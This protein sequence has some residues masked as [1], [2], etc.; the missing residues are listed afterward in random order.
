MKQ[1]KKN[2]ILSFLI[3]ATIVA[4]CSEQIYE[5]SGTYKPSLESLTL[6]I[7]NRDFNFSSGGGQ[8]TAYVTCDKAWSFHDVPAWLTVSPESGDSDT[9]I[10]VTAQENNT[11]SSRTAVFSVSTNIAGI[12]IKKTISAS[13]AVAEPHFSFANLSSN[14]V[15]L[16]GVAQTMSINVSTNLEDLDLTITG[17]NTSWVQANYLH[18][19]LE[20]SV[21]DNYE[22][23]TRTATIQLWSAKYSKGGIIYL[24]Q[25]RPQISINEIGLLNFD[26]IGG[27]QIV[28]INSELSWF[29]TVDAPWLSV[30][31]TTGAAGVTDIKVTALESGQNSDRTARILFSY[32]ENSTTDNYLNI[33]QK[34]RFVE[35]T[36]N[37][38]NLTADG[39]SSDKV[40]IK[41]NVGWIVTAQPEWVTLSLTQGG[42]GTH[43]VTISATKNNSLN[44]REGQIIIKDSMTGGSEQIIEVQQSGLEYEDP[45]TLELSWHATTLPLSINVP[46]Q[47]EANVSSGWISLSQYSGVG[48]TTIDISVTR[49]DSEELREG[50]VNIISEEK[51]IKIP[52]IQ[53]GQY[54]RIN[55]YTGQFNALGGSTN[56]TLSTTISTEWSIDYTFSSDEW[57][58]VDDSNENIFTLSVDYNPST[59]G[60][61][62]TFII[63]PTDDDV[64]E[65]NTEGVKFEINQLGRRLSCDVGIISM[66]PEGGTSQIYNFTCDGTFEIKK[67]TDE[68]WYTLVADKERKTFYVVLT[69]NTTH[70]LR[71]GKIII[72]LSDLP[73]GETLSHEVTINQA[74]DGIHISFGEF[75]EDE[76][77]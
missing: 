4:S 63:Y 1:Y 57:V 65:S 11:L 54:I 61:N 28:S 77:L 64:A 34:G 15:Y 53:S 71:T 67:E 51:T 50:T 24:T 44:I 20:I 59:K 58:N 30:T 66:F 18:N 62:A 48:E 22:D 27:Q 8:Q 46:Q 38:I 40:E 41:T 52:V 19:V 69:E 55:N 45:S 73:N 13:Q 21:E 49:N 10:T 68:P 60:R 9:Y 29:A 70:N 31:P 32:K 33:N 42:A 6:R 36:P 12:Q 26:A 7:S 17:D 3:C 47:W 72:S 14:T 74:A 25:N 43:S 5:E 23:I 39:A 56:L 75:G 35:V 16:S 76:K 2:K 37:K